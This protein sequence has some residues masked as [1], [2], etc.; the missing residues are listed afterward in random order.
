M[1]LRKYLDNVTSIISEYNAILA[2]H[3]KRDNQPAFELVKMPPIADR[4]VVWHPNPVRDAFKCS[5][6]CVFLQPVI[7][8]HSVPD[9]PT[10]ACPCLVSWDLF[11]NEDVS[12]ET[13]QLYH[14]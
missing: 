14:M 12:L 5:T 4:W 7:I 6:G 10:A 9:S 11:R 2:R 3:A 8:A 1:H 13:G